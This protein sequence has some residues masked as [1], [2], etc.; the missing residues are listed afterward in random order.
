[1]TPEECRKISSANFVAVKDGLENGD[2][3][4]AEISCGVHAFQGIWEIAAQ[5]AEMNSWL[6]ILAQK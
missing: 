2:A 4:G 3:R 6:R 1:M 5:L